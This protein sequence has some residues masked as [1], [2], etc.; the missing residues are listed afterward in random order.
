MNRDYFLELSEKFRSPHLWYYS[1]DEGKWRLRK[2][3]FSK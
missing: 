1:E 3:I 2:T